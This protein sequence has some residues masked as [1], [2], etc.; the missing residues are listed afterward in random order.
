MHET[1]P[2]YTVWLSTILL[3]HSVKEQ[4][5]RLRV[6]AEVAASQ[7]AYKR[8]LRPETQSHLSILPFIVEWAD[9]F[10]WLPLLFLYFCYCIS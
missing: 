7:G 9:L 3:S 10:N 2:I 1:T 5:P 6:A 4:P 8:Q